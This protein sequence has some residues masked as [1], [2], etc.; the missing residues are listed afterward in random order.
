MSL[1]LHN[2]KRNKKAVHSRKRVGRGPGSGYGKTAAR[3]HKGQKSRSGY[4]HKIG[5]EG[6]QMPLYR[7]LPKRGFYNKFRKVYAIVNISDLERRFE[8][9]A[10][11]SPE[12]MIKAGL[13][14]KVYDGVKVLGDGEIKK[15]FKVTA[16]KFSKGAK[17]KIINAGGNVEVINE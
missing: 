12:Q 17:E 8:N 4:S 1:G 14:K 5:F 6:G 9:G 15:T 13:I 16:H 10:E 2:L 11:I 3:G 7:R